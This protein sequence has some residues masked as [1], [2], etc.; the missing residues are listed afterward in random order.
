MLYAR[1]SVLKRFLS[2]CRQGFPFSLGPDMSV[3][4]WARAR[5]G[6][7]E[8]EGDQRRRNVSFSGIRPQ[9]NYL[10]QRTWFSVYSA[11]CCQHQF[12]HSLLWICKS[13]GIH[14][15]FLAG[16]I[17]LAKLAFQGGLTRTVMTHKKFI[18]IIFHLWAAKDVS[19]A[20]SQEL[21]K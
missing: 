12:S 9:L 2:V 6:E 15:C 16:G 5:E 21:N 19:D 20:V 18:P 7:G 1:G 4:V 11:L 8:R 13:E 17:F 14:W 3:H 10:L